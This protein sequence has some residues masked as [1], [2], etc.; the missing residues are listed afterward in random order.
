MLACGSLEANKKKRAEALRVRNGT[1]LL[2]RGTEFNT[3]DG[4]DMAVEV[5]AQTF[6]QVRRLSRDWNRCKRTT[7]LETSKNLAT[8]S[9][10][11]HIR[12]AL[13]ST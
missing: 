13:W 2:V 6:G 3:G 8:F 12:T 1:K 5:G 7:E 11:T 9:K 10:N 4:I